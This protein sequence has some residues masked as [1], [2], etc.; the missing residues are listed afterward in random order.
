[1]FRTAAKKI[2]HN[3]T[4]PVLGV[5]KDLRTLQEL[6][7]AEKSVLNS[8][9]GRLQRL[10]AD[11]VKASEALKAWGIGEGDD[12]G[13]VL[14]ASCTLFLHFAEALAN[15]ANHE[16]PVRE[17]MKSIR[18]RE[19]RLDDLRR[20]RKS[21]HSDADSAEKKLGKMSPDNKNLQVQT[22]L[23]NKLRDEIHIMDAD[24]MAEEASLG[25]YKRTSAKAWMG[26]KFGGLAECSEKGVII[27]EFGK[28]LVAEIPLDTTE[29]GLPRS[30]YQG[31]SNTEALVADARRALTNVVFSHEPN[32]NRLPNLRYSPELP[33][34]P[35]AHRHSQLSYGGDTSRRT[36]MSPSSISMP[37]PSTDETS[38][39][40]Q[41]L[42]SPTTQFPQPSLYPPPRQQSLSYEQLQSPT[43]P[44]GS[45]AAEFGVLP[46]PFSP[47]TVDEKRGSTS[48][49]RRSYSP[50]PP[51][52]SAV[53]GPQEFESLNRKGNH[54]SQLA[55]MANPDEEEEGLQS[56]E[57][58]DDR[59]V[60]FEELREP[61]AEESKAES[62]A[63]VSSR[64]EQDAS[65]GAMQRSDAS[66][67]NVSAEAT[68]AAPPQST[69]PQPES[70]AARPST[71][72]EQ[73]TYTI[74]EVSSRP[75]EPSPPLDEE[76]ALNAAAARE[77]SRELDALMFSVS[78]QPQPQ[79]SAA[80]APPADRTPSPL[81]PPRVPFGARSVSPRPNIEISTSQP[82][83]PRLG[84]QYVR[85][86]DR[87]LA[88]P[89]SISSASNGDQGTIPP[90]TTSSRFSADRG[91]AS[92]TAPSISIARGTPSPAPSGMSSSTP[93]RTPPELPGASFYSLSSA[94][95]GS[96]TSFASSGGKISAAAFRR[97]QLRSPS[98]PTL[99]PLSSA[100]TGPLVVKKRPLP[101][102]PSAQAS[103]WS[104]QNAGAIPRVPS[105]GRRISQSPTRHE[106]AGSEDEYDYVSAY[107]NETENG[108]GR[109]DGGYAQGKFATNLED[110]SGLR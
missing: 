34:I 42:R 9:S 41:I 59:R 50:P 104:A 55:Y 38:R 54:N 46:D 62:D 57:G 16:I 64:A 39:L 51:Q 45:E 10:S 23:L 78:P 73:P 58:R 66:H 76:K 91:P 60:T 80:D 71:G 75:R 108:S 40:S 49:Q 109:G 68:R 101:Q 48:S 52:Y 72:S 29:P 30:V 19:E 82:G 100:D 6:I 93:F 74:P 110:G 63:A 94:V 61:E 88:S 33:G 25:D 35:F 102:S 7:T 36:S 24:I 89:S 20:R 70:V 4:I 8:D 65:E 22:D 106:G 14:T 95:T 77:V 84:P 83:S 5:N 31:H 79:P 87:S 69:P 13:D 86:R 53:F 18:T 15:Y 17:H 3:S 1:M 81:Q 37:M 107:A 92:P 44:P 12:L 90:V 85:A 98:T 26:L 97:Q 2:A 21:L 43:P 56:T 96:G 103:G 105:A 27:G 11:L 28:M 99:D 32:P 47:S 67:S